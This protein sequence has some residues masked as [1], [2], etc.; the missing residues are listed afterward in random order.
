VKKR[1]FGSFWAV[2]GGDKKSDLRHCVCS[3][4]AAA[5]PCGFY[6]T[7]QE[8]KSMNDVPPQ[9][10]PAAEATLSSDDKTMALLAH[11][12][13]I[14]TGFLGPLVIWLIKKDQS[15]FVDDQ[16]KEALNFQI[17]MLIAWVVTWVLMFVLIGLLLVP[18][19]IIANLVLCIMGGIAANK[20]ERYRYPVALR[21]IK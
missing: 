19:L 9:V 13:G 7:T 3:L 11:L 10:E 17:T 16:G 14:F 1:R 6:S 8:G 15:T 4:A 2:R 18:V 21:L 5:L 20:G 12:L